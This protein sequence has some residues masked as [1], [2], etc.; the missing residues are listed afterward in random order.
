[1]TTASIIL[2]LIYLWGMG[3]YICFILTLPSAIFMAFVVV[4]LLIRQPNIPEEEEM[5][6]V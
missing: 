2:I 4:T 6:I 5:K 1:M 3:E